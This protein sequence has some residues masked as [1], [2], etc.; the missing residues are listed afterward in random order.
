MCTFDSLDEQ[1]GD[2]ADGD[3]RVGL[4]LSLSPF[5]LAVLTWAG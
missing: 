1:A 3:F 2:A 5:S 4:L